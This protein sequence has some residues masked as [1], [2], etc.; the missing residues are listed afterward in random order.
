[1][2][3]WGNDSE[4]MYVNY[5]ASGWSNATAISD[6]YG[7]NDGDSEYASVTVDGSGNMHVVWSDHTDGEWGVD[8][9][10]MYANY[11]AAGWSNATVISDDITGW[12]DGQSDI[13]S[14]AVEDNGILHVVWWDATVGEWSG[15][16]L[17]TEIMHAFKNEKPNSNHPPDIITTISGSK[18][19][20][21]VINDDSYEGQYRVWLTDANNNSYIWINWT[22]WT[23]NSNIIVS[24]N[25]SSEGIFNYTL[26]Y[27]DFYNQFGIPDTVFV[28][29]TADMQKPSDN[30]IIFAPQGG[31][32][33]ILLSTPLGLAIIGFTV[34]ITVLITKKLSKTPVSKTASEK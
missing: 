34:L 29:I 19:I 12:N 28:Y 8:K 32:P 13:P 20:N 9:E 31:D 10:I 2:G 1:I 15:G 3:E 22:K 5:T 24:I 4:I 33:F 27:Y 6:I 16:V 21:W 23:E 26:E 25:R 7:W 18:T 17:D 11:T 30:P 14:I